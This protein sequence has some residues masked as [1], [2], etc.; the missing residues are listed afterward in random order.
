MARP[1]NEDW[2][3]FLR[4]LVSKAID[5]H[6]LLELCR[7]AGC[8]KGRKSI[9]DWLDGREDGEGKLTPRALP[10]PYAIALMKYLSKRYP[11]EVRRSRKEVLQWLDMIRQQQEEQRKKE[12]ENWIL[13]FANE[14]LK[15]RG[16]S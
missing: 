3:W 16:K 11:E 10:E 12:T 7:R 15:R 6:G 4:P 2:W 14:F 13:E 8:E 5:E 9:R 1:M